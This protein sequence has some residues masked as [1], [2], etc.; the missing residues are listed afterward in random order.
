M[1][2][3]N[4]TVILTIGSMV[5]FTSVLAYSVNKP[6]EIN[7]DTMPLVSSSN[8]SSPSN[9]SESISPINNDANIQKEKEIDK[10]AKVIKSNELIPSSTNKSIINEGKKSNKATKI[11]ESKKSNKVTKINI[12]EDKNNLYESKII[13]K[14]TLNKDIEIFYLG[15]G[16]KRIAFIGG[17]HGNEPQG[18]YI[19]EKLLEYFQK[20]TQKLHDKELLFIP[21]ANPDS[22]EKGTRTNANGVDINRNFPSKNW[23]ESLKKDQYYSGKEKSSEIETRIM[24]KHLNYFNPDFIINIHSPYKVINYDGPAIKI[25]EFISK[26]NKYPITSNIGYPTLG[27]FGSYYGIDNNIPVITLETLA[28]L[29]KN[30]WETNKKALIKIVEEFNY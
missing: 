14:S 6:R 30:E 26:Y 1:D 2:I 19:V 15:K 28:G 17:V 25:A 22:F 7:S 23:K 4:L 16:S 9:T 24:L 27:S 8:I 11:N 10:N 21:K 12:R 20:N 5:I 18:V 13:E 3:K 29:P